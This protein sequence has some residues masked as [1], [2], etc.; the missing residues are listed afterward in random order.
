MKGVVPRAITIVYRRLHDNVRGFLGTLLE[1]T[2]NRLIVESPIK[3]TRPL[4][5]SGKVIADEGYLAI[6][7][8][9]RN[10]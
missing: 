5:V 8:I 3:C 2:A 1:A 9:Y 10:R 7:F 4:K 6:W